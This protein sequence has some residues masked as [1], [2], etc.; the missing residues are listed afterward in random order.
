MDLGG[1]ADEGFGT[2]ADAFAANL[3]ERGEVG[4]ALAVQVDGRPVIDLWGG[5]ADHR[6]GRRWR[7]DTIAPAYSVSKGVLSL[8]VHRLAQD[9]RIDLD[10][11]LARYW[12]EFGQAGKERITVREALSHRAGVP[13]LDQPLTFEQVMAWDPVLAALERQSPLWAPADGYAYHPQTFGWLAGEL[14]RRVT[15][16]RPGA[17][18]ATT[19]AGPLGLRT[20]LGLPADR[21][22][23]L[24]RLT[25]APPVPAGA[26]APAPP[27]SP[28][29]VR[30]VTLG[31]A[32]VF[33][34]LDHPHGYNSR[35]LLSGELPGTGIVS[36][37]RSLARLY[38][39]AATGVDG[40]S[41]LLSAETITDAVRERSAGV[42]WG[43]GVDAGQRWGTGFLLHSA[44]LRHALGDR[45]FGHDGAGGQQT[46]GDDE[47]GVG[48]A[49]LNN[50]LGNPDDDRANRL[51]AALH[52]SLHRR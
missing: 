13:A 39:A 6:D 42:P 3:A 35:A 14:I 46:F 16:Q 17:R 8:M 49:Y 41:R 10:A 38:A 20:W 48:F 5:V 27:P 22:G 52:R 2:V 25:G 37:A 43:G 18:L 9:G 12:P 45:S 4:A 33:P 28:L 50:A 29:L 7:R 36:D 44:P 34:D 47:Y 11:P 30:S 51:V 40:G 1:W 26:G 32:I 24:A 31:G 19:L 21:F 23:D 15:G